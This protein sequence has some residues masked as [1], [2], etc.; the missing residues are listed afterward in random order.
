MV[1]VHV[2]GCL[3]EKGYL[4]DILKLLDWKDPALLISLSLG[5]AVII[6]YMYV[7]YTRPLGYRVLCWVSARPFCISQFLNSSHES[8]SS[9]TV[10]VHVIAVWT[11]NGLSTFF[12]SRH[13]HV[14][15]SLP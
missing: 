9:Q 2:C 15:R 1:H 8:V 12:T 10:C 4:P 13:H 11:S 3:P 6:V 14:T 7:L 5:L